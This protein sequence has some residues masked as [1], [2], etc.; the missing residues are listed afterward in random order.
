MPK[1]S[2]SIFT[3]TTMNIGGICRWYYRDNPAWVNYTLTIASCNVINAAQWIAG[4]YARSA[5]MHLLQRISPIQ[6]LFS[7]PY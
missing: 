6:Q 2:K 1:L 7:R 4:G 5:A 3:T